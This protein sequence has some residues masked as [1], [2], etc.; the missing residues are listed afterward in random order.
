MIRSFLLSDSDFWY[1][2]GENIVNI[3][4][5]VVA[6]GIALYSRPY[7]YL[8]VFEKKKAY[9]QITSVIA[10]GLGLLLIILRGVVN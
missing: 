9:N 4:L 8:M 10:F 1:S 2:L 5:W 7:L 6:L 3:P